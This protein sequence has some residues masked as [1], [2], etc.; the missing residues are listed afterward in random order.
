MSASV[1][2]VLDT[3]SIQHIDLYADVHAVQIHEARFRQPYMYSKLTQDN[4]GL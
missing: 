1:I 3:S 4:P 2:A